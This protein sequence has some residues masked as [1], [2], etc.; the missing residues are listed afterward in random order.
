MHAQRAST[1]SPDV[2]SRVSIAGRRPRLLAAALGLG[3]TVALAGPAV[4][5]SYP[6]PPNDPYFPNQWALAVIKA[7]E[8]WSRSTGAGEVVAVVD[9]GVQFGI[10][11]LPNSKSAGAYNCIGMGGQNGPC[12]SDSSGDDNGHGTWVASIIAAATDNGQGMA[13]VAP[14]ARIMSIRTIS[15]DGTGQVTDIAK[16]IM[17][18]ADQG[19]NVINLSVGP[20]AFG[21][22]FPQ[23]NCP[24]TTV[25]GCLQAP[26]NN[27]ASLHQALQPA[28][29]YATSK[30]ALV[31]FAAGNTDPGYAG[32]S[33]YLGMNN[34][35]IVGATG[36]RDEVASYSDTGSG[37][38][39]IWAPGGD[40]SCS[41]SDTNNCI[42]LASDSGGYV[43]SEGTSFAAPHVAGVAALLMA[44]GYSNASAAGRIE[45]TA[46][47][48][49][50]GLRLD[51]E[52]AVGAT[53]AAPAGTRPVN[54]PAVVAP[55]SNA[56]PRVVSARPAAKPATTTGATAPVTP[57]P[58]ASTAP[59]PSPA[60]TPPGPSPTSTER[61]VIAAGRVLN[62]HSSSK[63]AGNALTLATVILVAIAGG[64]V[65]VWVSRR[66][67]A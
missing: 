48:V 54:P 56:S 41:S 1:N 57:S 11:D 31:I 65:A 25:G 21:Q 37:S 45:S 30:G 59:S 50:A 3:L 43:V 27:T 4:A 8:A 42:I 49:P 34:V 16:G 9:T 15:A 61:A 20:D 66:A 36:P 17:F 18:A 52:A 39:F 40:G 13:G 10:P 29:D 62:N 64:A 6:D 53:G 33:L 7:P 12:P 26:V 24:P 51:A 14:D 58:M 19:A 2:A 22:S 5:A 60:G 46:D 44:E 47:S 32:P 67:R 55:Q 63:P 28:V 38:T 35:L 23:L